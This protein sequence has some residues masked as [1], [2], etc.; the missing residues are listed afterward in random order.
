MFFQEFP[1]PTRLSPRFSAISTEEPVGFR[2]LSLYMPLRC[3]PDDA[4][5]RISRHIFAIWGDVHTL[6]RCRLAARR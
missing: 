5:Q 3:R 6:I 4:F 1:P 2:F